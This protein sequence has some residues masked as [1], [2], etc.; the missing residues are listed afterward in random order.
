MQKFLVDTNVWID[1][2][3]KRENAIDLINKLTQTGE[4][5]SS[6]LTIIELRAGWTDEKSRHFLPI[7]YAQTKI[8]DISIEIAELAGRFLQVYKTKGISLSTVDTIIGSTAIMEN[9]QLVTGN[10]KDFPM[11]EIKLYEIEE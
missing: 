7:F 5:F 8:I 6:I 11:P 4:V 9:C 2:L 3:N 10:K 1:F